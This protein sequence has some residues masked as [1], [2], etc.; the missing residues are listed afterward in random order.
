[1]EN[2]KIEFENVFSRTDY[3]ITHAISRSQ[4]PGGWLITYA[5]KV[6]DEIST[7]LCFLPDQDHEWELIEDE[8]E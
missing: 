2:K 6:R 5:L 7:A 8:S 4:V 3:Y 1:M